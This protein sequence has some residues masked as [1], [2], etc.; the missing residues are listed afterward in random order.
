[1][2]SHVERMSRGVKGIPVKGESQ[3]FIGCDLP[4]RLLRIF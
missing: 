2:G 1:M 4:G 3:T